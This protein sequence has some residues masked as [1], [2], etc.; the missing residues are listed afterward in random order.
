MF[1]TLFTVFSCDRLHNFKCQ[2]W[3]YF[4]HVPKPSDDSSDPQ[5]AHLKLN[6]DTKTVANKYH[7]GKMIEKESE[8]V[9]RETNEVGAVL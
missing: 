3:K 7:E 1:K 8:T 5:T 6:T 2:S 4:H 9:R